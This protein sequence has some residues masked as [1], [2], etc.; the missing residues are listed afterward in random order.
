MSIVLAIHDGHN[1]SAAVAKNGSVSCGIQEERLSGRKFHS[2]FPHRSIKWC[3]QQADII[4]EQISKVYF[5]TINMCPLS[6]KYSLDTRMNVSN[7]KELWSSDLRKRYY[8]IGDAHSINHFNAFCNSLAPPPESNSPLD[9]SFK[10][11]DTKDLLKPS[12]I[13]PLFL[14]HRRDHLADL[15]HI[16][17]SRIT[18]LEHHRCHAAYAAYSREFLVDSKLVL[19][20]DGG[21]DGI[22]MGYWS[23]TRDHELKLLASSSNCPIGKWWKVACILLNMKPM[24]DEYKL[25]GMA[26]YANEKR[27][28]SYLQ[29]FLDL[30]EIQDNGIIVLTDTG[31]KIN[32]YNYFVEVFRNSRFDE[33]CGAFQYATEYIVTKSVAQSLK[34]YDQSNF[35]FGGGTSMNVKLNRCFNYMSSIQSYDVA[36]SGGDETLSLGAIYAA[37]PSTEPLHSLSIGYE[38]PSINN[39][40]NKLISC[41]ISDSN[42]IA[43]FLRSIHEGEVGAI[44]NGKSEFGA[45]AL[46]NRSIV[47]NPSLFSSVA[48]INSAIKKRDFWMPFAL[49]IIDVDADLFLENPKNTVGNVMATSFS[50]KTDYRHLIIAGTHPYDG[51]CRAQIIRQSDNEA[52]YS[53]LLKYKE[54]YGYGALLNTSL[55]LHGDPLAVN[56]D[57]IAST[58]NNSELSLLLLD[59]TY[60]ITKNQQ[61]HVD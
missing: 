27:S 14:K 12:E 41:T 59:N 23:A 21:G 57:Q 36:G 10:F 20:L 31:K 42:S 6:L 46:G 54:I 16:D 35:A 40:K 5:S 3:M 38:S 49:T 19:T 61:F 28:K 29:Y 30:V 7:Y 32:H 58:F 34:F 1:C 60:L 44:V 24:D 51:S 50:T 18:F 56:A 52:Y 39:L 43:Q 9:Y 45:R 26:P 17:Q 8:T 4:S 55:N 13:Q 48:K 22:T 11:L 37:N 25:M 2:G 47:A 53:L 33:I 15:F